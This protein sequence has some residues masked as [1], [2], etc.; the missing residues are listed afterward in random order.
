MVSPRYTNEEFIE[1]IEACNRELPEAYGFTIVDS[2]GQMDAAYL[3]EKMRI[4]DMYVSP[5][6]AIGFHGHNNRQMAFS[7]SM[8]FLDLPMQH[9]IVIDSSIMG[10]GKG[11]GNLCTELIMPHLD[12][13]TG[14]FDTIH[15]YEAISSLFSKL[16]VEH[17][18][19]YCLDFYVASLYCCTPS[20]VNFFKK[21]QR[22]GIDELIRLLQSIPEDKKAAF[23][24]DTASA[25]LEGFFK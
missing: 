3:A 16:I 11:A 8:A 17:P 1:L 14:R 15:I 20:Y 2:F 5:S 18:W 7:N 10:M 25:L 22:V 23:S 13:G 19:G 24:R 21:D 4:A 9:D 12:D 6:M